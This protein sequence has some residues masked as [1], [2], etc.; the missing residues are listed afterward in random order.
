LSIWPS[1]HTHASTAAPLTSRHCPPKR[2][3]I[4]ACDAN[5]RTRMAMQTCNH[6]HVQG[7]VGRS[8][9]T[10][11]SQ[12][13]CF[14]SVIINKK[15]ISK[16][17]DSHKQNATPCVVRCERASSGK[18]H[19]RTRTRVCTCGG[20]ELRC[21]RAGRHWRHCPRHLASPLPSP[22]TSQ[23][24]QNIACVTPLEEPCVQLWHHGTHCSLV[25]QL[26][27]CHSADE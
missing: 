26:S 9:H 1:A 7:R 8:R 10:D 19:T 16:I 18:P 11:A 2:R 14:P 25:L 27:S 12:P 24:D 4:N 6:S 23:C 13:A 22:P 15:T 21:L 3:S 20:E 5:P 17:V